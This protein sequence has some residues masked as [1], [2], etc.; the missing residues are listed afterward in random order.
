[1]SYEYI[2]GCDEV[3]FGSLV[4]EI[5]VGGVAAPK[6]WSLEGLND[7]KKLSDKRRR[8]MR[9]KILNE[10]G[11]SSYI[12]ERN[13]TYIDQVGIATALKEAYVEVFKAL[14]TENS[15]I[16]YDGI[17]KFDNMGID[18]YNKI[19][20]IKA[21]T[22]IP[23]VMAAS[24]LAK[25]YRDDKMKG[26]HILHSVYGWDRN[27]GYGTVDHIQAIKK[28]GFSPLHRRS[29]NIKLT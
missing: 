4:G 20:M 13:N 3:G 7:S 24:I 2:V 21:D 16:I 1:M 11:I 23:A 15:L 17:L 8:I 19:S 29:Y 27:A 12:A 10:K 18:N 9:D 22:K 5:C 26:Y 28:Y 25:V 14:Y 6:D